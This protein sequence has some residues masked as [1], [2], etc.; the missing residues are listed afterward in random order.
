MKQLVIIIVCICLAQGVVSQGL[1]IAPNHTVLFGEDTTSVG[2]KLMWQPSK[3]ALRV[4][5]MTSAWNYDAVGVLSTAFGNDTQARGDYSLGTGLGTSANSFAEVSLGRY[6]LLGGATTAWDATGADVVFEIG[7]GT[8]PNSAARS[9]MFTIQKSG[10]IKIGD[11]TD[12]TEKIEEKLVVDGAIIIKNSEDLTPVPGTMRFN[13]AMNDFEGY[14]GNGW[15]SLTK[16]AS[17]TGSGTV[18][19]I[20]GN[21]YLTV[22]IGTQTWMRENLRTSRYRNGDPIPEVLLNSDWA[23]L[24]SGAWSWYDHDPEKDML[25]GKL[26]NWYAVDDARGVCPTGWHVPTDTEWT[27]LSDYLGGTGVAGGKMKTTGTIQ[28]ETG[29]W[30]DPNNGASNESGFT[31]LP[32][33][34]CEPGGPFP[35]TFGFE[36]VWWSSTESSSSNAWFYVLLGCCGD[37]FRADN[38]KRHGCSIRCIRD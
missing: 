31:G 6:S 20:D 27:T 3:A 19:D 32:G 35:R 29:Y 22:T 23:A 18:T 8:G 36:G 11:I 17:P 15:K 5:Y 25:Y 37:F 7:N 2:V 30:E 13:T 10:N 28:A 9:N 16:S 33:S 12:P 38:D 24:T 4:G 26:Y 34:F 1:H 21:Q 14:D